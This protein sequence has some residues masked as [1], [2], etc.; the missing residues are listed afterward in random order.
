M[1]GPDGLGGV[2]RVQLSCPGPA[3]LDAA[4]DAL[5][6]AVLAVVCGRHAGQP[7]LTIGWAP[8]GRVVADL[9]G[10]PPIAELAA[11]MGAQS[12]PAAGPGSG[13]G[14]TEPFIW[15][16]YG[17]GPGPDPGPDPLGAARLR[18]HFE[19]SA[20][21]LTVIV[22]YDERVT[23]PSFASVLCEHLAEAVRHAVAD[24][25]VRC[26]QLRLAGADEFRRIGGWSGTAEPCRPP[27]PI[28][29]LVSAQVRRAPDAVAVTGQG[30]RLTYREL[31]EAAATVAGAL[32][33]YGVTADSL[34]AVL[35]P[36]SVD[37]VVLL[38][39]ILKTGGAYLVIDASDAPAAWVAEVVRDAAP[40]LLVTEGP[41]PP[42]ATRTV[43]M[44]DL[45]ATRAAPLARAAADVRQLAYVS[46]TSGTTGLAKGVAVSHEAVS[47]LVAGPDW[48][49]FGPDDVFLLLSAI[50]FDASTFELWAP[51]ANGGQIVVHPAGRLAVEELAEFVRRER[52]THAW[53]TAG[54]FHQLID[55][56]VDAF[57]GLRHVFAGG[58]V[59]SAAHLR[60]LLAAYPELRFT[61]GYGP[62]ENTT[63]T[64][65]WTTK[66]PFTRP[67]VPIG[68]PIRGTRVA[69]LSDQLEPVPI[70][71]P[72]QLYAGGSGLARGYH[73]RPAETAA[74]F[75]P[76]PV[77]GQPGA[78][79]YRTGDLVRWRPDGDIEFLGRSDAQVK[80]RGYRV[81]PA[82]I[83]ATLEEQ[84]EVRQAA[85]MAET[86]ESGG[87]RIVGYV[88]LE[89][90]TGDQLAVTA[91]LRDRIAANLPSYLVPAQIIP[92]AEFPL[93]PNGKI[94]HSKLSSLVRAV[95]ASYTAR[96][97]PAEVTLARIWSAVLGVASIDIDDN[98][99]DL[100]GNSLSVSELILE[101]EKTMGHRIPARMVF[102]H[103][104]IAGIADVIESL[105]AGSDPAAPAG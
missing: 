63:F 76:D 81:E 64:T 97:R 60:R 26:S 41:E 23:D 2:K 87:R 62:T 53:F 3:P 37:L 49:Q 36:R 11:E 88:V 43:R 59:V 34:V 1:T 96:R 79:L 83:A 92:L 71:V 14:D 54:L 16:S 65:C 86:T 28:D 84:P 38:L 98:F 17:A 91:A 56:H 45:M 5:T 80:I 44:A 51:L 19:F 95:P 90:E 8:D 7:R 39:G 72:G 50:A 103:A 18:A 47:R 104:T 52:V 22:R 102:R 61:N 46:Y 13:A 68:K 69:V 99:F 55:A 100:G 32:A 78:R 75:V 48:A 27:L 29:A 20:G 93:T 6:R 94:D 4:P 42:L 9:T 30:R 85:V 10:D 73:R 70:G 24:P 15:H 105:E 89:A 35:A 21:T 101:M 25:G 31:D 66:G 40:V 57:A 82:R 33:G 74:A 67:V 58:D 12:G 77:P